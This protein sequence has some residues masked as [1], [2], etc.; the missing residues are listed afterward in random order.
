MLNIER[1]KEVLEKFWNGQVILNMS[2]LTDYG[3]D[4]LKRILGDKGETLQGDW[5]VCWGDTYKEQGM[6]AS[7]FDFIGV[8]RY[9]IKNGSCVINKDLQHWNGY[10]G[11]S[12][13]NIPIYDLEEDEPEFL[14]F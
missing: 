8:Q 14:V 10:E 1:E 2:K 13:M 9:M 5:A 11:P 6:K 7:P 3:L 12:E 4:D